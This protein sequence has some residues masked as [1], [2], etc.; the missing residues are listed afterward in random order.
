MDIFRS[1][2]FERPRDQLPIGPAQGRPGAYVFNVG[3]DK[4]LGVFSTLDHLQHLQ[5]NTELCRRMTL[6][7]CPMSRRRRSASLSQLTALSDQ[8]G[9][10]SVCRSR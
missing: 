7:Q 6:L 10:A 4:S 2:S 1:L 8:Y 3:A 9:L 5:P